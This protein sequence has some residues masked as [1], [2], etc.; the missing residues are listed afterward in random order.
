MARVVLRLEVVIGKKRLD[1]YTIQR[2][3]PSH[4]AYNCPRVTVAVVWVE[5]LVDAK[6]AHDSSLMPV[7]AVIGR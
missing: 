2:E 1:L 7:K 4:A 6:A 5:M 3:F